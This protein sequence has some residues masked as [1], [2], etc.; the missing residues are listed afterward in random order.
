MKTCPPS[1]TLSDPQLMKPLFGLLYPPHVLRAT[2]KQ[3]PREA[4]RY[5]GARLWKRHARAL[6]GSHPLDL[7]KGAGDGTDHHVV[8]PARIAASLE[9]VEPQFRFVILIVLFD[10]PA[11]MGQPHDLRERGRGW[12][13]HEVVFAAARRPHATLAEQPDFWREPPLPPLRRR[14]DAARDDVGWL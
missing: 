13:R 3:Q 6:A 11:L 10:R 9:V 12:Q 5:E 14:G 1:T 7:E 4:F 2:D 8:L